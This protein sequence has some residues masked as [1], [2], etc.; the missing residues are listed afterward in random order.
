[1]PFFVLAA[2]VVAW[3]T[4]AS[5]GSAC[6]FRPDYL[7]LRQQIAASKSAA[8]VQALYHYNAD[9]AHDDPA[10]CTA[11][12]L[13]HLVGEKERKLVSL[14]DGHRSRPAGLVAHCFRYEARTTSC[15]DLVQDGTGQPNAVHIQPA[16]AGTPFKGR[17]ESRLPGAKLVAVYRTTLSA[18]RDGKP[19]VRLGSGP[20]IA[21][22]GGSV[23]IAIFTAPGP[24][25]HYRKFVWYL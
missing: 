1:M 7:R 17:V 13:E 14:S 2:A 5:D 4:Q 6:S 23:L 19:A 8:A 9:P 24:P 15:G 22:P 25:W 20:S 21:V 10:G 11:M 16:S 18:V 3:T 12:D